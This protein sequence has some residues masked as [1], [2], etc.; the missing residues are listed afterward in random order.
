MRTVA[1]RMA[2]GFGME[3]AQRLHLRR[4]LQR[5]VVLEMRRHDAQQAER[6]LELASSSPR[7][8]LRTAGSAGHGSGMRRTWVTG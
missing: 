8:M 1:D 7:G 4:P 6:R 3:R 5:R 2:G